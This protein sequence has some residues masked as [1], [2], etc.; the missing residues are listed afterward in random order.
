M[1]GVKLPVNALAAGVGLLAPV[2]LVA[3]RYKLG[4]ELRKALN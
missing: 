2:L 1:T 4:E 3:G